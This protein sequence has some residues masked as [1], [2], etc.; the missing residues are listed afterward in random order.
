MDR[1]GRHA[2]SVCRDRTT[3]TLVLALDA[4][5][6]YPAGSIVQVVHSEGKFL[7][8]VLFGKGGFLYLTTT[9]RPTGTVTVEAFSAY[10]D[11]RPGLRD[12][13]RCRDALLPQCKWRGAQRPFLGTRKWKS[14]YR[15]RE[16]I[17]K[18]YH[19]P[20]D[21]IGP[22]Y[23]SLAGSKAD[24]GEGRRATRRSSFPACSDSRPTPS[25]SPATRPRRCRSA[26]GSPVARST[27]A[28]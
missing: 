5:A 8:T 15:R 16:D 25:S 18:T 7:A 27:A 9:E 22:G 3:T 4:A 12:D 6:S 2:G 19:P 10:R 26:T 20:V 21:A 23:A 13:A 1:A 11:R 28:Q 24:T 14:G 17:A